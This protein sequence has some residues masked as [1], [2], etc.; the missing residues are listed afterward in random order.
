MKKKKLKRPAMPGAGPPKKPESERRVNIGTRVDPLFKKK[1]LEL[2]KD[3]NK[4][5]GELIEIAIPFFVNYRKQH[6]KAFER[7]L[8]KKDN[9]NSFLLD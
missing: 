8:E 7:Y 2:S 3:E 9:N 4:S 1:F 5:L 6:P